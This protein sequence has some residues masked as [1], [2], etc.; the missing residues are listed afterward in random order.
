MVWKWT[1]LHNPDNP[2]EKIKILLQA[3]VILNPT[4][5]I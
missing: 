2:K 3:M 1:T 4:D 5:K